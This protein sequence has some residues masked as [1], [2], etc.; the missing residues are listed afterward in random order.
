MIVIPPGFGE[1]AASPS[2]QAFY[3]E[4]RFQQAQVGQGIVQGVLDEITLRRAGVERGLSI[5]AQAVDSKGLEYVDFLVPGIISMAIMQM[6]IFSVVFSLI[7]F[8]QQGVLRR[9]YAT[10][11]RPHNFLIGQVFTRLLVSIVQVAVLLGVSVLIFGV[12]VE[13]NFG[14]LFVLAV[15]GGALFI[16]I[17][18]VVSGFAKN[19]EVGAPLANIIALPMMFLS[20][21]FFPTDTLPG[22]L[23]D[24]V[25]YLPL[26]FL[27]DG[28]R[29]VAIQGASLTEIPWEL[30]GLVVWLAIA[31]H[32]G[33]QG[34]QVGVRLKSGGLDMHDFQG[35]EIFESVAEM[36]N[37]KHTVVMVHDM[38]ND[39]LHDDGIF[40][41]AGESI[42]V[43]GF[44]GNLVDFVA[45]A[46]SHGVRIWQT[47]FT[48]LP[49]L[50][51]Y[52]DPLANKRWNLGRG[53]GEAPVC[54]PDDS[55]DLGLSDD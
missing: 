14:Y 2:V 4:D 5:E 1:S 29:E 42:D 52:D 38:Q 25:Q 48:S 23:E 15:L 41:K 53:P 26:T 27:A 21:V 40:K 20:G 8:R 9:L 3:A 55:R 28:M 18:F 13:G 47:N 44:L 43:S 32:S 39:F 7:Q 50:G 22:F 31:F 17:G 35:R 51:A 16:A 24:I 34:F 37:P 45:K 11:I 12:K 46:R 54:Q 36:V 33:Y 6:G 10:P 49:N 30:L 19:E